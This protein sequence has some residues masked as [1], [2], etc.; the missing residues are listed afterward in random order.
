MTAKLH[1]IYV[2]L[3]ETQKV[4]YVGKTSR[5]RTR[6]N[7]HIEEVKKGN[8]LYVYNKLRRVLERKG[9]DRSGIFKIIE[10]GI[11]NENIDAREMFHIKNFRQQGVK[12]TN[13]TDGGEGGK[14]FTRDI[15]ERGANKRRGQHHSEE[16]KMN[17]S[18]AK[19]GIPLSKEHRAA[20]KDAWKRRTQMTR[21]VY[22]RISQNA[23]GRVNI[24][25]FSIL[26]P[27]GEIIVTEHGLTDFCREHGLDV[28][29]LHSTLNGRRKHHRGWKVIGETT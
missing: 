2:L 3:D 5:P 10:D 27:S 4:F 18:Q 14:G 6:L 13:L 23:R 9:G 29:N 20:L 19:R 15:I 25:K 7:R 28:R 12:L 17:I 26:S 8:H 24:K 11:A 1:C 16:W 22:E 21:E